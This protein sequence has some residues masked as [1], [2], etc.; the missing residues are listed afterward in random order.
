MGDKGETNSEWTKLDP[1]GV[2][3]M[4]SSDE[5]DEETEDEEDNSEPSDVPN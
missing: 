2:Q 3:V 4:S 5:D 1:D